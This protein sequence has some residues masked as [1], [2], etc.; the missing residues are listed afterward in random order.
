MRVR[1]VLDDSE[2]DVDAAKTLLHPSSRLGDPT[3][4]MQHVAPQQLVPFVQSEMVVP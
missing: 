3:P 1:K 4:V 2:A